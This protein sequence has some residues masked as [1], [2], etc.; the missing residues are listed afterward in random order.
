MGRIKDWADRWKPSAHVR[1]HMFAAAALWTI[2]GC[3]LATAGLIWCFAARWPGSLLYA[4]AGI[5]AGLVKGRL[6]IHKFAER[7]TARLIAR[8]DGRCLGGFL[9]ARTWLVVLLMMVSGIVL[10][11]SAIPRPL[12][13]ILYVA[14]GTALLAGCLPLWK[15]WRNI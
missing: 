3:G 15:A 6:I 4:A 5:A 14:V 12:L 7:N 8:G 1:T 11:H 2:V 9:S 10:R 13:G